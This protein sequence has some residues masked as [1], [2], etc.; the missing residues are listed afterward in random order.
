M[1]QRLKAF[2]KASKRFRRTFLGDV[3]PAPLEQVDDGAR[4]GVRHGARVDEETIG[5]V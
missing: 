3:G 2:P 1:G 4:Q 5:T